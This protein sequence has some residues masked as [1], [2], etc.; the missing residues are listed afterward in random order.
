MHV[1]TGKNEIVNALVEELDAAYETGYWHPLVTNLKSVPPEAWDWVPPRGSRTIRQMVRHIGQC[2]VYY[3]NMGFGDG[4]LQWDS[5]AEGMPPNDASI[6]AELARLNDCHRQLRTAFAAITDEE[7]LV[8]RAN[9]MDEMVPARWF[10]S[11]MTH[12]DL[13]HS[14]EINHIRSLVTE[15]DDWGNEG[16]R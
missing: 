5:L 12:H 11:T 16:D 4:T 3:A 14:G 13:Y 8:E 10:I 2:K 9:Q 15:D 6:D 1:S 7:L